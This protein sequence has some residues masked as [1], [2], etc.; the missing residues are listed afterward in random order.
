MSTRYF[1]LLL[2]IPLPAARVR[3]PPSRTRLSTSRMTYHTFAANN[4]S[5]VRF[6]VTTPSTVSELY[7]HRLKKNNQIL[8]E[9]SYFR[10]MQTLMMNRYQ[11]DAVFPLRFFR[12]PHASTECN[13]KRLFDEVNV[14]PTISQIRRSPRL[15][16]RAF[17]RLPAGTT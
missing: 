6:T 17:Y 7:C 2:R 16:Q 1:S 4:N 3:L 13:D 9:G 8:H 15:C 14:I 5:R 12:L 11:A 10:L